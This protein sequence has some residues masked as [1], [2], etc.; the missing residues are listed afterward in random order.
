MSRVLVCVAFSVA[1]FAAGCA[2]DQK[3]ASSGG[4]TAA[5]VEVE[6]FLMRAEREKI[7]ELAS[8]RWEERWIADDFIVTLANGQVQPYS[9]SAAREAFASGVYHVESVA[10][11][12]VRVKVFGDAAVV[13]AIQT[14]KSQTNGQNSSGRFQYTHVWVKRGDRW[15]VVAAHV[16]QLH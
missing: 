7:T 10:V 14:E 16:T 13:T 9:R 3:P 2:E 6:D 11:G 15:Q 1:M 5:S 8:G 4:A 12:D